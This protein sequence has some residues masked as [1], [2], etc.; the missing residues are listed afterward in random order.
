MLQSLMIIEPPPSACCAGANPKNLDAI[1]TA[2]AVPSE[3]AMSDNQPTASNIERRAHDAQ[4]ESE[5]VRANDF[6]AAVLAM[7]THDLRQHLQV[8]VGSF[9]L[10]GDR[11]PSGRGRQ[12]IE[13]GRQA[14][15]EL[16]NR[17]DQLTDA[18]R[19]QQQFGSVQKEP[20]QLQPLFERLSRQL[21]EPAREKGIDLRFF[22][23]RGTLV[24]S[25]VM[26]D[27][28]VRN[29]VRNA[30]E[31]TAIGGRVMVG[32]RRRGAEIRIEVRDNGAGI[33]QD[34][35][36]RVFEP[37]TRLDTAP[38]EGLGLGLF[39]VARAA[40]CLGHSVEV[41]SAPGRGCCFAVA[42]PAFVQS[43]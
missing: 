36:A 17:F 1:K 35:L 16:T 27:G 8:I 6:Y 34:Q 42:V 20:V 12:I 41:R 18:L 32:C 3:K 10:V 28:I 40:A 2:S 11:L 37:F 7:V 39:I 43:A 29:L 9:D 38:P 13:R 31:H 23:T 21:A 15:Q 25:E 22:S 5:L 4:S 19:I 26:L 30:L 14:S 33:G 24:S